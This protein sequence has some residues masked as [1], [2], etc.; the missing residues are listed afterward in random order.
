MTD[1]SPPDVDSRFGTTDF[2]VH[3]M[4]LPECAPPEPLR[5]SRPR[6]DSGYDY[7]G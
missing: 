6:M 3:E 4:K 5:D 7:L 2:R 1:N